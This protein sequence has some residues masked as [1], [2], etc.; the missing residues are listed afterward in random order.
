VGIKY[1][2]DVHAHING[3][4]SGLDYPYFAAFDGVKRFNI[5]GVLFLILERDPVRPVITAT[6]GLVRAR[7]LLTVR[8]APPP[9]QQVSISCRR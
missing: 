2:Y 4:V 3:Y 9:L 8:N 5:S 6:N 7:T 1:Q